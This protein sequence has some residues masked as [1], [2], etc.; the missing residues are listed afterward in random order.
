MKKHTSAKG[1]IFADCSPIYNFISLEKKGQV[2]VLAVTD[3]ELYIFF[4]EQWVSCSMKP[5]SENTM[6]VFIMHK[7]VPQWIFAVYRKGINQN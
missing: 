1:K 5:S 7:N 4:L 3:Q 6:Q 2:G